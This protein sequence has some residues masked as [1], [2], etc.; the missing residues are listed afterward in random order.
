[1]GEPVEGAIS[2]AGDAD[3]FQFTATAGQIIT[4]KV[5]GQPANPFFNLILSLYNSDLQ[6]VAETPLFVPGFDSMLEGIEIPVDGPYYA[7]IRDT[8]GGRGV[9][10]IYTLTL[11][12]EAGDGTG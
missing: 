10:F 2:F 5:G 9:D 6:L 12:I 7:E 3:A 4:L 11:T 8:A 1:M